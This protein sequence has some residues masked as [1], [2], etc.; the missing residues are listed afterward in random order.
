MSLLAGL[1]GLRR[2]ASLHDPSFA[3]LSTFTHSLTSEEPHLTPCCSRLV[4]HLGADRMGLGYKLRAH[5]II[6]GSAALDAHR[7]AP[8]T[9]NCISAAVAMRANGVPAAIPGPAPCIRVHGQPSFVRTP[10]TNDH[11]RVR[12]RAP[13]RGTGERGEGRL[14]A[15]ARTPPRACTRETPGSRPPLSLDRPPL[16]LDRP[17]L[18]RGRSSA[19]R[20]RPRGALV[21]PG[22]VQARA[23]ALRLHLELRVT[24]PP[25]DALGVHLRV[26]V[27]VAQP[28]RE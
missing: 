8:P 6:L 5:G 14:R 4:G 28:Q 9:R 11:M 17:P 21:E 3:Q 10:G 18:D 19:P 7:H 1:A 24:H 20:D 16:S 25:A 15:A 13:E 12:P 26:G 27:G 2:D 22:A 23:S